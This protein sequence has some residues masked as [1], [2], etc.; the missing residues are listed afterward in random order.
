MKRLALWA[1]LGV[2][3]LLLL[4]VASGLIRPGDRT[5]HSAL[6]GQRLPVFAL[7]PVAA[8]KPGLATNVF[9][10][11]RPRLLNVFASWC[12]PCVAEIPQL[13]RL[14]AMGV[15]I[16]GL[17]IHDTGPAITAFLRT[18]GDPYSRIGNDVDAHVQLALG[19]S[20]VPESFVIDGDGRIAMQKVGDIRPEDVAEIAAAVEKAR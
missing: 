9:G 15:E 2:F 3:A 6:V 20:G 10:H 7:A 16:D 5:I 18:N 14:K 12:V 13:M 11:G 17:A 19:S 4:V 1:P 8:G